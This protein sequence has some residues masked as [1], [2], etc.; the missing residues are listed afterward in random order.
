MER[1][2]NPEKM[3]ENSRTAKALSKRVGFVPTM[4]SLHQGHLELLQRSVAECEHTVLS[5]FVNP[6]QFGVN[7]D[8]DNYPRNIEEDLEL[9]KANKADV[10]FTP[11]Q[12]EMYPNGFRT[13]VD[14][15]ADYINVL[16]GE[17]RPGHFRGVMTVVAKLFNIVEADIAYFGE[18]DY[19]QGIVVKRMV[20]DLDM[21]VEIKMVPTVR[22]EDGLALSSRNAYLDTPQREKAPFIRKSLLLA[23]RMIKEKDV[24]DASEIKR[25]ILDFLAEKGIE[26]VEYVEVADTDSLMPLKN[27]NGRCVVLLAV[28]LGEA[29]LID[30]ITVEKRR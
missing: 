2:V 15:N 23:K 5:I 8:Y 24:C 21:P 16:C 30:N 28:H 18:K 17:K 9:C 27:I 11:T 20:E 19:Q 14:T 13:Y 22:E 6:A 10:V 12:K 3:R 25:S 26:D 29:R 7:E 1:I 4:G